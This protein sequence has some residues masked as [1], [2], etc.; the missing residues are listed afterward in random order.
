MLFLAK[1]PF[2]IASTVSEGVGLR[3]LS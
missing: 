2:D 1:K 3:P